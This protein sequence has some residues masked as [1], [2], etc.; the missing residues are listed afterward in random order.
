[1]WRIAKWLGML[2]GLVVGIPVAL[3][4]IALVLGNIPPGR[5]LLERLV[6]RITGGEVRIAGL[7]GRFPAALRIG[8]VE[9][10]DGAGSYFVAESVALDWS[11]WRLLHGVLAI[12]R[13][14]AAHADLQ[15]L[16]QSSGSGSSGTSLP[17][18]LAELRVARLDVGAPVA[19]RALA[20][21]LQ[22]AGS[23]LSAEQGAGRL[24]L[25]QLAGGGR[26]QLSGSVTQGTINAEIQADEPPQGLIG[27]IANL[28]DLG[29]LTLRVSANG[30]RDAVAT[31]LDLRAGSLDATASGRLDLEHGAAD[32][33][34]DG[35]AGAMTPRPDVS[36][37]SVALHA[38]V[39]G[40]FQRPTLDGRL[41]IDRLAAMEAGADA[42]TA[43]VSGDA[44][45]A[46]LHAELDGVR[47][48]STNPDLL[49]GSPLVID[50]TARLDAPD[51]PVSVQLHHALFTADISAHTADAL[52]TQVA[53]AVPDLAPFA[54][55]AG[56]SLDGRLNA[57]IRAAQQ[58]GETT[59]D[60]G[61]SF[62]VTGGPA[63]APALIG[64][65]AR[66][67][68]AGTMRGSTLSLSSLHV[69]GQSV[70]FSLA[71]DIALPA[72]GLDW[73][74]DLNDLAAVRPDLA[75]TLHADG[76]VGGTQT[77]LTTVADLNGQVTARGVASGPLSAH[78]EAKS[79]P[80]SPNGTL[81]AQ[82][83]LLGSP[84]DLALSGSRSADG[85]MRLG[86][87][88]AAWKSLSAGGD[89]S[90]AAG[91][92]IPVGQIEARVGRLEDVSPLVGM[93][94]AGSVGAHIDAGD[95]LSIA[96]KADE[97][98]VRGL[99]S[100]AHANLKADI[101]SPRSHPTIDGTLTLD[102]FSAQSASGSARLTAKGPIEAVA[103]TVGAQSPN[104]RGAP[105]RLDARGTLDAQARRLELASL[106]ADWHGQSLVSL[107]PARI[108]LA[109]G[110]AI[111]RLRLRLDQ[112]TIELA[113]RAGS[114]LDLTAS[115]HNLPANLAAA[116]SS[117]PAL[118]GTIS[119]EA[120]LAGSSA[121]PRG[122]IRLTASGLRPRSLTAAVPAANISL[123]A[124]L[125][126]DTA[127]IDARV[128]AG[129]SR[130]TLTGS[131]PIA[132]RGP[133]DLRAGGRLDL[134]MVD[135][136]LS[137]SGRRVRGAVSLDAS[138][139]GELSAPRVTG[140]ARLADGSV[141]DYVT[142][143]HITAITGRL[144]AN[145]DTIRLVQITGHAGPGTLS[146]DGT[147]GLSP[148]TVDL[149]IAAH[150]AQPL[151]S[152]L[153]TVRL[154]SDV[155]LRGELAGRMEA[156]GTVHILHADINLPENMP[157]SVATIPVRVAGEKPPPPPAPPLDVGLNLTLT[158]PEQIFVRGRGLDVELGGTVH[159]HGTLAQPQPD[160]GFN[161]IRGSFSIAGQTLGFTEGQIGFTGAGLTDPSLHLVAT[162][163]NASILATLTVGGTARNPKITLSS[164]P[165]L[166]QDEILSQLLFKQSVGRLG[167]FQAAEIASAAA[168]L[169]G[170]PSSV[171][172]PLGDVRKGLGLDV[173]SLG[174]SR[175]GSPTLDAG[176]YVAP[177]VYVGARQSTSGAGSQGVVQID[178]AKGLKL[179]TTVGSGNSNAIGAAGQSGGTGVGI[180]YQFQY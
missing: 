24:S 130:L 43:D 6:P 95:T 72:I 117:S 36:W 92:D 167:P 14:D 25:Q 48:A 139:G 171:S 169:A 129:P 123:P 120:R 133:L 75:G 66:F 91:A 170:A 179:E 111:D 59:F 27:G 12:D 67:T 100:V 69:T 10:D 58:D 9:L 71:G 134:A 116:V 49:A 150:D 128:T 56:T 160:G 54:A 73:T 46:S 107:A 119:A 112:S 98:A 13:L 34:L 21:S 108:G 19:G 31:R 62:G 172:N 39:H 131:A 90:L 166:P 68:L 140:S 180:T 110:I 89:L 8:R 1:M 165:Q 55:A 11:P 161:L 18:R 143:A 146:I 29:A 93:R 2:L 41:R 42:L 52:S 114:T 173:L 40:P 78:L 61:G 45:A 137:A 7:A 152:D 109:G 106:R 153:M 85:A 148:Q 83:E 32:L 50:A 168:S 51:R 124:D 86:I 163:G 136:W 127:R 155:S 105:A 33:T 122:T 138:I 88:R 178:I 164:T 80:A 94:L 144:E 99:A 142:G 37:Q 158:A 22:G 141:Q 177:R 53:L 97:V 70:A 103:L 76:H 74:L 147:I 154:D 175:S 145:G 57:T 121:R 151:A 15:R 35:N 63:P 5:H 82:G 159:V 156:A 96:A 125:H 135:P 101:G 47:L 28:P 113:G 115:V 38:G 20:F 176:R 44:G 118:D 87:Q 60:A 84:I 126:G 64:D 30:P 4:A 23:L 174:T 65:D 102:G 132:G 16:P 17:I 162:T 157:Q 149:R 3:F 79:L 104:L 26:Y 81:T 77:D